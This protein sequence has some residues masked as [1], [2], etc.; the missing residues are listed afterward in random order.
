MLGGREGAVLTGGFLTWC[1]PKRHTS[2]ERLVAG[3]LPGLFR[4]TYGKSVLIEREGNYELGRKHKVKKEAG[5]GKGSSFSRTHTEKWT[6]QTLL[7]RSS[8]L[9]PIS[10]CLWKRWGLG[11]TEKAH[12]FI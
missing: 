6:E 8:L 11:K 5:L 10:S 1:P 12:P 4:E 3:L 2:R 7:P 9:T